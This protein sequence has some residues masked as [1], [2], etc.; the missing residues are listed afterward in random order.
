[1][2]KSVCKH[3]VGCCAIKKVIR[4]PLEAKTVEIGKKPTCGRQAKSKKALQRQP[5]DAT[6]ENNMVEATQEATVHVEA[7][8]QMKSN[9]LKQQREQEEQSSKWRL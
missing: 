8:K 9:T 5:A 6:Q 1:M 3:V 4:I 2:K 7:T